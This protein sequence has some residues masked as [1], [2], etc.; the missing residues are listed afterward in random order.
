MTDNADGEKAKGR[1]TFSQRMRTTTR[2]I[3]NTSD[4]LVNAKLG[5]T[6]SDDSVW[7]EGLL[8]FYEI[9]KFL[10]EAL[11][12][13]SDSLIGDLLIP[14]MARTAALE[15]DLSHYLGEEWRE[16]YVVRPEVEQYLAHLRHLED[17][18]PYMLIPY[19]YHLYMGLFSG[20]QVLKAQRFLSLSSIAGFK[21]D[22][23][24]DRPGYSVTN[25][26]DVAIGVLKK[27]LKKAINDLAEELD[28]ETR[29]AILQ[30]G[31]KVFKLNNTIIGSVKGVD[32]VLQRRLVKLL[33]AVILL[34]LFIFACYF[35]SATDEDVFN[36]EDSEMQ[37]L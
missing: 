20:G 18:D 11:D 36:L 13:H 8:V 4:T 23:D 5:V 28:E 24:E 17:S 12:R 32:R 9:F 7:A 16:G 37:E 3:H 35:K 10:E 1:E 22:E 33:I 27:N 29:E 19:I 14:G 15:A 26:G 21:D 30:E 31:V 34:L 2:S 25:Y 6:M